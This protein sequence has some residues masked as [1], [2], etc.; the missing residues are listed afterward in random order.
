[1]TVT[2]AVASTEKWQ[3]QIQAV[4][5]LKAVHGADLSIEVSGIVADV[6]FDS[7]GDVPAGAKLIRLVD[8]DDVAKLHTLEASRDLWQAN[9]ARDQQQLQ[10]Q[11][12]SQ[13]Q[14][15]ITSSNLKQ[16]QAQIAEQA[17]I[18]AKKTLKAPFAG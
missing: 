4:G 6:S 9:Y 15:D 18:V 10:R 12:I 5:S 13:A 2:T 11:L 3:S 7:G 1:A 17:A 16:L 8:I 14:F